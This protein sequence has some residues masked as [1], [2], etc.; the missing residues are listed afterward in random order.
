MNVIARCYSLNKLSMSSSGISA[1]GDSRVGPEEIFS[2]STFC[3]M[4]SKTPLRSWAAFLT[5][6]RTKPSDEDDSRAHDRDVNIVTLA[7]VKKDRELFFS[8]ELRESVRRRDVT[9]RQRG[10]GG[11]IQ[12]VDVAVCGDLLAVLID[13]R[14]AQRGL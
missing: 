4:L 6:N 7:L 8:D 13:E 3:M 11:R 14:D 2:S 5:R 1:K 10:E 12:I 9:R